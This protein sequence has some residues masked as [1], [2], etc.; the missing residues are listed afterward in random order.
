MTEI[1]R[2]LTI[3]PLCIVLCAALVAAVTDV[4]NFRI[5]NAVTLPLLLAGVLYHSSSPHGAGV[6][7]SFG[8]VLAGFGCLLAFYIVGAVGAGDVKLLAAAGAWIGPAGVLVLFLAA[9]LLMGLYAVALALWHGTL[10]RNVFAL[11]FLV[12]QGATIMKHLGPEE[13]VEEVVRQDDRRKRLIPFAV[14][15]LGGIA[16][17]TAVKFMNP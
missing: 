7:F 14:M 9:A 2:S 10:Q 3:A 13:R 12:R 4:R 16:I 11:M 6:L 17:L 5:P 1:L 8:G 15:V